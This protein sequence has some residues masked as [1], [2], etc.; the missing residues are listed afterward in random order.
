M[1]KYNVLSLILSLARASFVVLVLL[2]IH[3]HS[4]SSVT[5]AY[6]SPSEV[7]RL[8]RA[9]LLSSTPLASGIIPVAVVATAV[10]SCAASVSAVV[11][12]ICSGTVVVV[13][14]AV[15]VVAV[16]VVAVVAAGSGVNIIA[17]A[18]ERGA[19]ASRSCARCH[20]SSSR[21]CSKNSGMRGH[22]QSVLSL[23]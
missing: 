15:V 12:T 6:E 8:D 9:A 5:L 3:Y 4:E 22:G 14:V 1:C 2:S 18:I 21:M 7:L 16:V 11:G 23:L 13:V 20:R 10:A 19:G 17:P